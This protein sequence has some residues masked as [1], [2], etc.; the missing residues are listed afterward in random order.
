M[1]RHPF[2]N[3]YVMEASVEVIPVT[4]PEAGLIEAKPEGLALHVP[5]ETEFVRVTIAPS[6]T[7]VGPPIGAGDGLTVT[8]AVAQPIPSV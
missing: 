8:A 5:P 7:E 4:T 1:E 6:Q 2:G 3:V